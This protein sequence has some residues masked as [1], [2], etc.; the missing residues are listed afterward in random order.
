MALQYLDRAKCTTTTT[1]TGTYTFG[2]ADDGFQSIANL[3]DTNTSYYT[4][5][6][7][8]D[9]EVGIGTKSGSTL[10]RDTIL[11]S[12]NAGAAVNWSAGTR[13]I[14]L[15][16]PANFFTNSV[17]SVFG[18]TGAVTAQS[19]D[20]TKAQVGLSN[21]DNTSDVNK[22]VST[23]QQTAIDAKVENNLTAS[24]TVAPSKS[25]VNTALALKQDALGFTPE[26]VA[27]KDNGA[28]STSSTTYP[29]SGATKTYADAK[30]Q[31]SLTASTTIAPSA[32]AVNTA[33]ALKQ[34]ALGFTPENVANKDNGALSASTTTYPTSGATKT[35]A[36]AK[37]QNSLA[38]STTIA[39]SAT[40]VNT[41]LAL[42]EDTANKNAASGYAGLAANFAIQFKNAANTFT[43]LFTNTNTAIRTYTF[44]DRNGTIADDT[45]LGLKQSTSAKD[46]TGGYVG[47]T[48]FKINFKNAANTF[49]S[50]FTNANTAARTYT[51][52]NRDG[53][54]ADDTDLALKENV[55]SFGTLI[56]SG[57]ATT[58]TTSGTPN[59]F[60]IPTVAGTDVLVTGAVDFVRSATGELKYTGSATR[61]F[62]I[63]YSCSIEKNAVGKAT[64]DLSVF[65]NGTRFVQGAENINTRSTTE[66]T[67]IVPISLVGQLSLA[68][69]DLVSV[70]LACTTASIVFIVPNYQFMIT[71]V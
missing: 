16:V 71:S 38:A 35:Y 34:D 11:D 12:S 45:D 4:V 19:G 18:R 58:L 1:G 65:K 25:A 63:H 10:T 51:F 67:Y 9:W 2:A 43:S 49:T 64:I 46:A 47:L 42:K 37:V 13:S 57:N 8:I 29:T 22:P 39:P 7:G 36:D 3:T 48:L 59:T 56:V 55:Q 5:T 68:T 60:A 62:Q 31:N 44:Q 20:Y 50:F 30:V 53:T 26:N 66:A 33:L 6:D 14:F 61:D 32:T 69:N 23:A 40:A 24:T 27:N 15:D 17:T 52:Q 21:V 28:L 41:A 54:I 70:Q